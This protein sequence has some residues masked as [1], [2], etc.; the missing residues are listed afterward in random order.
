MPESA[1]RKDPLVAALLAWLVPGAG[2]LYL[3]QRWKAVLFFTLI[4]A[5]FVYGV[6]LGNVKNVYPARYPLGFVA[7]IFTGL[8]ALAALGLTYAVPGQLDES[9]PTFE[10]SFV[11]SCIAGLLNLLLVIDAAYRASGGKYG[12]EPA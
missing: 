8:P 3:G 5:A 11:Y 7:Q 4:L 12:T 9:Q 2:H 6:A 1:E 10:L